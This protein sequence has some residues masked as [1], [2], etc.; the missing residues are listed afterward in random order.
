MALGANRAVPR[1][2]PAAL[3]RCP[4][5]CPGSAY[6]LRPGGPSPRGLVRPCSA[7]GRT[8]AH[9]NNVHVATQH[10]TGRERSLWRRL[11]EV[12]FARRAVLLYVHVCARTVRVHLYVCM[13]VH[14]CICVC[15]CACLCVHLHV[16]V[17]VCVR[18]RAC[19]C[20]PVCVPVCI[21]M[22]VSECIC[23][24]TCVCLHLHVCACGHVRVCICMCVRVSVCVHA[25]ACVHVCKCV[26][27][28]PCVCV[29][30]CT[31]PLLPKT[32]LWKSYRL[33]F[34]KAAPPFCITG[35]K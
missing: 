3:P 16:C 13:H 17:H 7:R 25:S 1:G 12:C 5:P 35:R 32:V 22:C 9:F 15:A 21:C 11:G 19:A 33:F 29:C 26:C 27:A 10:W 2:S 8:S 18:A 20:V 31:L 28:C 4:R 23:V 14:V 6:R 30:A 34:R 24:C